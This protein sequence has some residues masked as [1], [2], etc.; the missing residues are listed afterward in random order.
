MRGKPNS[1][2]E[3]HWTGNVNFS[4]LLSPSG[5]SYHSST[6][7]LKPNYRNKDPAVL[8][9]PCLRSPTWATRALYT[10]YKNQSPHS[11]RGL[12][13]GR[14][15]GRKPQITKPF[16]PSGQFKNKNKNNT[17]EELIQNQEKILCKSQAMGLPFL[18]TRRL[19][20]SYGTGRPGGLQT[21]SWAGGGPCHL[22]ARPE[23]QRCGK[24]PQMLPHGLG[25]AVLPKKFWVSPH[26][27][28]H[29]KHLLLAQRQPGSLKVN[30]GEGHKLPFSRTGFLPAH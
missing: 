23:G 1:S 8:P 26:P 2:Y 22:Q 6:G 28:L 4:S 20:C 19:F 18:R 30:L 27:S 16:F 21:V 9:D 11:K 25:S 7:Y 29:T 14:E 5:Y 15:R 12:W 10:G 24:L 17:T 13:R 3:Q